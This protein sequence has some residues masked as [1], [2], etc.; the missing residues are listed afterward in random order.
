MVERTFC[1]I[2]GKQENAKSSRTNPLVRIHSQC[3]T[4]DIL[5]SLKCDC[6]EQ[7]RH[8]IRMMADADE[9]VLYT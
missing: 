9:G 5:E 2:L 6:G 3:I 8:S 7:L 4:G 1:L